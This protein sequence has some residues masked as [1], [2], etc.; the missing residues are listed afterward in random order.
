[1][2]DD[3]AE[4]FGQFLPT[5]HITVVLGL[6]HSLSSSVLFGLHLPRQTGLISLP[7]LSFHVSSFSFFSVSSWPQGKV[8]PSSPQTNT[9][10]YTSL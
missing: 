6:G 9:S 4:T 8:I 3:G 1:M 5:D 7:S 2:T 10:H